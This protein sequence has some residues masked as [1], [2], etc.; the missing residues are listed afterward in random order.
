MDE[1]EAKRTNIPTPEQ[2]AESRKERRRTAIHALSFFEKEEMLEIVDQAVAMVEDCY[3][4][5]D[6]LQE[7][8]EFREMER[9]LELRRRYDVAMGK[10]PEPDDSEI[11]F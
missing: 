6:Y 1:E 9:Q 11:P 2:Y 3:C 4:Q 5:H 7:C 10:T 8:D